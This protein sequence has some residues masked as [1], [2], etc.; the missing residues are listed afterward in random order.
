[1]AIHSFTTEQMQKFVDAVGSARAPEIAGGQ[2]TTEQLRKLTESIGGLHD[3]PKIT[4]D[5]KVNYAI[6]CIVED[7]GDEEPAYDEQL[8]ATEIEAFKTL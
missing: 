7:D 5:P 8:Y 4:D 3:W 1:M 6:D 2:F